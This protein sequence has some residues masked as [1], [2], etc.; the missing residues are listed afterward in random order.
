MLTLLKLVSFDTAGLRSGIV[1]DMKKVAPE[2]P[3][4]LTV[5]VRVDTGHSSTP[6]IAALL[7]VKISEIKESPSVTILVHLIP[8]T[9]GIVVSV[10]LLVT[11][12]P[13]L[14]WPAGYGAPTLYN[15][16]VTLNASIQNSDGMRSEKSQVLYQYTVRYLAKN[17]SI[18]HIFI[19]PLPQRELFD[20]SSQ[21]VL[22]GFREIILD[23]VRF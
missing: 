12:T 21:S 8:N 15:L 6:T 10:V 17:T 7:S 3:W 11:A 13:D 16:T 14:W 23:Q 9:I 5:T 20:V 1:V 2:G 19:L 22:V 4:Q 18:Q